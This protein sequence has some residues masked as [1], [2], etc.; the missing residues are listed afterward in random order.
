MNPYAPNRFA[1]ARRLWL[2]VF[3]LVLFGLAL[4][5]KAPAEPPPGNWTVN[6]SAGIQRAKDENK[7]AL[8]MF[9]ASWCG[10]C[11]RMKKEVFT[12]PKV[13][14]ALQ[15]WKPIYIDGDKERELMK[16]YK[17]EA[18]PTFVVV[19]TDGTQAG[20]FVGGVGADEFLRVL[21]VILTEMPAVE[22]K[23]KASP[24]D[25]A[26]WKKKGALLEELGRI[27]EA[28]DAFKKAQ[29]LDPQDRTRVSQDVDFFK[30]AIM[31]EEGPQAADKR[32]ADFIKNHPG[33]SRNEDALFNRARIAFDDKR[34][35]VSK[36]LLQ[37]YKQ[38]FPKGKYASEADG[39]LKFIAKGPPP[40]PA[41]AG[42]PAG[43]PPEQDEG[44]APQVPQ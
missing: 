25:P 21:N 15:A 8:L 22:A 27:D 43:M 40:A 29:S 9:S 17:I 35:D 12:D 3:G 13:Q 32:F 26:L 31:T 14:K 42:G 39:M 11:N 6:Y 34:F 38:Q 44:P 1:P 24:K 30:A 36:K 33:S 2:A 23:L 10:P 5:W 18:F 37:Q 20:R 4:P 16:T 41:A 7:P 28:V 19:K